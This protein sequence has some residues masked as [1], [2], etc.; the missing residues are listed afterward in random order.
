MLAAMAQVRPYGKRF[1]HISS[2]RGNGLFVL[3]FAAWAA[4]VA[5]GYGISAGTGASSPTVVDASFT[6]C[7]Q[8]SGYNCVIDG[9][10]VIVRGVRVRVEGI[11]APETHPPRCASEA[12]LGERATERLIVLMNQ[13]PVAL[14]N[15]GGRDEDRY[16]RKLRHLMQNGQSLGDQLIREGLARPWTGR[17]LPWC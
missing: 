5:M 11:D 13:G 15:D 3:N 6:R 17:K 12:V 9:D 8:G 7:F 14:V 16:G 4:V 1:P 10:T 2:A